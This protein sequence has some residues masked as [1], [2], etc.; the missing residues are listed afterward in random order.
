MYGTLSIAK[1]W[2]WPNVNRNPS[3]GVITPELGFR[4]TMGPCQK[5][6]GVSYITLNQG[7]QTS[8]SKVMKF[9]RLKK[10]NC[11]II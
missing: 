4:P 2:V 10:A 3:F 8:A 6:G 1:L 11:H 5:L 7:F 9:Y